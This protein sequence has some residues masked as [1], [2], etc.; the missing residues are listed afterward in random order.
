M[1]SEVIEIW[2]LT[3]SSR[4]LQWTADDLSDPLLGHHLHVRLIVSDVFW[5][6]LSCGCSAVYAG[7]AWVPVELLF[8]D[9]R[10]YIARLL[11]IEVLPL[12]QHL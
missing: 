4:M 12:V 7:A 8:I 1:P 5:R 11:I 3:C 9:E 6:S 2:I 10:R